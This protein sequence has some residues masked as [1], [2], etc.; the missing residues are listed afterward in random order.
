MDIVS[1]SFPD[2]LTAARI[3]DAIRLCSAKSTP[4]F[5]GF[6]DMRQAA[7]A[8]AVCRQ[9]KAEGRFFGGYEDAERRV[10]G[11]FPDWCEP[12]DS[13]Y[14]IVALTAEYRAADRLTHRDFLGTLMALGITRES[15]GDILTGEGRTVLFVIKDI[16]P[17]LLAQVEKVGGTGVR[18]AEGMTGELPAGGGFEELAGTVSSPRLDCMVA[19]LI[20]QS[21]GKAQQ[22]IAEGNVSV[23]SL[24]C[25]KETRILS[26]GDRISIR[27]AGKFII[28]SLGGLSKKGR[29]IYKARKYL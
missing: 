23:N 6:L 17:Y 4:R 5:V 27:G 9:E 7:A 18:L 16:A 11:V 25:E 8:L 13:L 29:T 2:D 21:R 3:R 15:V 28:D 22:L 1:A 12:D 20:R 10:F 26:E 14:P 19:A 24:L